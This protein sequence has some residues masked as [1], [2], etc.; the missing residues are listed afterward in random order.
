MIEADKCPFCGSNKTTTAFS[1]DV[2]PRCWG[3]EHRTRYWIQ[4]RNTACQARGPVRT[5]VTF[6]SILP[7]RLQESTRDE[8]VLRWNS[9]VGKEESA[10]GDS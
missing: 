2:A 3:K 10:D 8:V 4:C 9:R 1:F 5:L 6:D 7:P